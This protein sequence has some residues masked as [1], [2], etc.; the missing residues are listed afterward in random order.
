[1]GAHVTPLFIKEE[2]VAKLLGHNITWL[3]QRAAL[4]E[5]SYGLPKIDPAT[6]LRHREAVEVWA[7]KRNIRHAEDLA[8]KRGVN[9]DAI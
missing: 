3:R 6:Q 4:L 5:E 9:F 1:M 2:D 7:R 8:G